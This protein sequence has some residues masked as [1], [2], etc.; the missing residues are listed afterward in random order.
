MK[1]TLERIYMAI[2]VIFMYAPIVTLIVL[3]FNLLGNGLRDAFIVSFHKVSYDKVCLVV[4]CIL[5]Q[6]TDG[7]GN[8]KVVRVEKENILP[9]GVLQTCVAGCGKSLVGLFYDSNALVA[10]DDVSYYFDAVVWRTV[11]DEY[12]FELLLVDSLPKDAF[13]TGAYIWLDLV[14]GYNVAQLLSGCFLFHG[15]GGGTKIMQ[16]YEKDLIRQI[17]LLLLQKNMVLWKRN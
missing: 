2:I 14:D 6:W 8:E 1:K 7:V 15:H 10:V 17:I 16:K 11:V 13:Q 12:N 4:K 9:C 5:Q 3:S